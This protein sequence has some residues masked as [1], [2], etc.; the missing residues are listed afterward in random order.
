MTCSSRYRKCWRREYGI[1]HERL[2]QQ[3]ADI[4]GKLAESYW[5]NNSTDILAIVDGS[6]LMDYDDAGQELQFKSAAAISI[7]YTILERCGFEPEGI[8]TG[9]IFRQF[10][11]FRPR[12]QSMHWVRRSAI[13]AVMCYGISSAP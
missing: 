1:H 6:F 10:T 4:A 7:M 3:I 5:D 13:A 8:L 11:I 12:M 2:S 9:T